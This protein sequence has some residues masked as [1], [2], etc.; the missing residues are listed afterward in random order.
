MLS[1]GLLLSVPATPVFANNNSIKFN[2]PGNLASYNKYRVF[3]ISATGQG[4]YANEVYFREVVCTNLDTD[5]DGSADTVGFDTDGDG[6]IDT[7]V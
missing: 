1:I 2:M 6:S 4:N 3:G 7:V 5:G